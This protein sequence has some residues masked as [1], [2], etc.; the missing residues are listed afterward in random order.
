MEGPL[1]AIVLLWP[2]LLSMGLLV[3]GTNL[4]GVLLPLLGHAHG[5]SMRAVGLYSAS[6]STGFVVACLLI[7]RLLHR[8]G[9]LRAF[10]ILTAVSA[11]SALLLL[12]DQDATVWILLRLAIGFCF[13][14]L[15]AIVESWIIERTGGGPAF[16]T[17]F[18][19]S[20]LASL[21]GTLSLDLID[22]SGD[23]PFVLMVASIVLSG[24][25]I[26]LTRQDYKPK[27]VPRYRLRFRRLWHRSPFGALDVFAAG[28]ITGAIGGLGPIYGINA[29]LSVQKDTYMLA[30]NSVGGALAYAPIGMLVQWKV[31]RRAILGLAIAIGL[32][33]SIPLE[34]AFYG[35]GSIWII[36]LFGLFGFAQYPLYG[37]GVGLVTS[38]T[39]H[40]PPAEVISELLLLYG[41]GTVLGPLGAAEAI[42]AGASLFAFVTMILGA[43]LVCLAVDTVPRVR[44]T[45]RGPPSQGAALDPSRDSAPGSLA[46]TKPSTSVTEAG[47]P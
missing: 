7:G 33:T 43:L 42:R 26:L 14:G 2:V 36:V 32:A 27:P 11:V 1:N 17:Y 24:I 41:V 25:P 18:I 29:G 12:V 28:V 15:S 4:Q 16:A 22:N 44:G 19:V 3:F 8:F 13:G 39:G 46:T 40:A 9:H 23:A 20:L 31:D 30:A 21:G 10:V 6:W 5:A 34:L 45:R 35:M 47:A 38:Q 37:V